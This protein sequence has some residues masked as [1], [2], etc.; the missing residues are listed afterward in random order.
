MDSNKMKINPRNINHFKGFY[1]V[2]KSKRG[3]EGA[4]LKNTI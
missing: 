3:K 1:C 2:Y 4:K